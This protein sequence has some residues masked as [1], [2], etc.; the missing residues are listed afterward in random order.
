MANDFE[1]KY[2]HWKDALFGNEDAVANIRCAVHY[3]FWHVMYA[4][5]AIVG[6]VLLASVKLVGG[7]LS[8]LPTSRTK[9]AA[10]R[11]TGA[12]QRVMNHEYTKKGFEYALIGAFIIYCI[13][14]AGFI[15]YHLYTNLIMS[16]IAIGA[17]ILG[18]VAF[19]LF[20]IIASEIRPYVAQAF[21]TAG[22][23]AKTAANQAKE[24]PAVRRLYGRCPVS[25]SITPEWFDKLFPDE[26]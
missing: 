1:D 4:L 22:S 21:S 8:Y 18:I 5:M 17:I 6:V 23:G 3:V 10:A 20:I 13:V 24:T 12:V 16:L 9:N 14:G 7:A 11:M 25:M 2:P 19:V 26:R 15:I